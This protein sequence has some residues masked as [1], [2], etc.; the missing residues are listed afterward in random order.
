MLLRDY[1]SSLQFF[2]ILLLVARLLSLA[3]SIKATSFY[4]SAKNRAPKNFDCGFGQKALKD[5]VD[6]LLKVKSARRSRPNE[7]APHCGVKRS[8][9]FNRAVK[10]SLELWIVIILVPKGRNLRFEVW[11][12]QLVRAVPQYVP[13]SCLLQPNIGSHCG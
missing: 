9:S 4:N 3:K 12:F 5:D 1:L 13:Q 8:Q 10:L 11:H 6:K 2:L 7:S